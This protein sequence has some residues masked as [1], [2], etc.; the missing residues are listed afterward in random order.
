MATELYNFLQETVLHEKI[1]IESIRAV[2]HPGYTSENLNFLR[3]M[4][5][6]PKYD[7]IFTVVNPEPENVEFDWNSAVILE[8]EFTNEIR[9]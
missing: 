3:K 7:V 6:Y 1:L 2:T 5:P 9:E 8:R 4:R